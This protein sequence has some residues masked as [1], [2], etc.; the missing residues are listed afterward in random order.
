VNLGIS[1][2]SVAPVDPV[3]QCDE[4]GT[5]DGRTQFDLDQ[6]VTPE[7]LTGLP[8][9]LD[10]AYYASAV[11]AETQSN[12]LPN[13]FTNTTANQQ[14][15]YARIVNGPD[16]FGILPITL[17]VNT[18][19][20]SG[21]GD[22]TVYVCAGSS[23]TLQAP[24]GYSYVWSNGGTG[25]T[26]T[27]TAAGNYSATA[28]NADGC[29]AVKTFT[30]VASGAATFLSADIN[31][32]SGDQNSVTINYIGVGEGD[33]VFSLDGENYQ[34]SPLFSGLSTGEYQVFIKDLKGCDIS[35]PFPIYVLDYPKFFTP[36]GDGFNDYWRVEFPEGRSF[37]AIR[38]YD[39]YG[40][41]LHV[42]TQSGIG[43]DGT[44]NSRPLASTD[45]WFVLELDNG[46]TIK[47]HFSLKR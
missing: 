14:V 1:T 12:A 18:F 15:I 40:K 13:L 27:V 39:R 43:W 36:N 9:G 2:E 26:I 17:V 45:Y 22:S 6:L 31:D 3:E 41:L 5:P 33:Y 19:S 29:T 8:T 7:V 23:V 25:N 32:F 38:I 24:P 4:D 42:L 35:G 11:D 20:P 16:C 46:R 37:V 10:V 21:F 34:P 44:F 28:T 30:V 47:G